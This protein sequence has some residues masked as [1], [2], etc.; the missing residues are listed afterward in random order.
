MVSAEFLSQVSSRIAEAKT[1]SRSLEDKP[2][3]G[4]NVIF[5]GDFGQLEPVRSSSVF[6]HKLVADVDVNQ[7]QDKKKQTALHGALLWRQVNRVVALKKNMRQAGD[8]HYAELVGRVREGRGT[9]A[10][11]FK[12]APIIVAD[13]QTRDAVNMRCAATKAK[14]LGLPL[15][16]L[17]ARD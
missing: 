9:Q 14:E 13:R 17:A 6:S 12:D 15:K 5:T 8:P 7:G 1:G 3:G 2:F 4:V 16:F 10:A 11:K